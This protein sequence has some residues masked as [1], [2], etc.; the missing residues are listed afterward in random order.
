MNNPIEVEAVVTGFMPNA[1][2]DHFG[3]GAFGSYDATTLEILNPPQWQGT[4]LTIHHSESPEAT[5]PWRETGRKLR[6]SIEEAD[7]KGGSVLFDGAVSN[8]QV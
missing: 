1:M 7:L 6:F 5:S 2:Q 4:K 3:S 8:V